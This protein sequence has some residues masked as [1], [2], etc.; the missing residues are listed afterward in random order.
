M[1]LVT[2]AY[3]ARQCGFVSWIVAHLTGK[4]SEQRTRCDFALFFC[5]AARHGHASEGN[6]FRVRGLGRRCDFRAGAG[7]SCLPHSAPAACP[8]RDLSNADA[9][10]KILVLSK[11]QTALSPRHLDHIRR[12][13]HRR[14][15]GENAS[16]R[17]SIS[18]P[19][20]TPSQHRNPL[21]RLQKQGTQRTTKMGIQARNTAQAQATA[22]N[23]LH[24]ASHLA[25]LQFRRR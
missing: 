25:R 13:Y 16:R 4:T 23:C 5:D 21:P 7:I 3:Y 24:R 9:D 20:R 8:F 19:A 1:R 15:H 17:A 11:L 2:N 22:Q 12:Q 6:C 14:R 10:K 18:H